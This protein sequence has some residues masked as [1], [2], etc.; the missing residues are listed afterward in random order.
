MSLT[1]YHAKGTDDGV[2]LK[3]ISADPSWVIITADTGRQSGQGPRLPNICRELGIR[4]VLLGS[5]MH[6]KK[7]TEKASILATVWDQIAAIAERPPGTRFRVTVRTGRADDS[8]TINVDEIP[9]E[10]AGRKRRPN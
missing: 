3:E 9:I 5:S 1:D 7:S 4:H 6:S 8:P 10:K 2:W